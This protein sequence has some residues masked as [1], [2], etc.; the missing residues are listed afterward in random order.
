MTARTERDIRRDLTR[1][2]RAELRIV[3]RL[4][5]RSPERTLATAR[6]ASERTNALYRELADVTIGPDSPEG[7]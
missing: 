7:S 6:A 1:S 3:D 5:S 4:T 2:L